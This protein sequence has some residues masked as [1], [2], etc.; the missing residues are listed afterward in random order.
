VV[1]VGRK[2]LFPMTTVT[3][4]RCGPGGGDGRADDAVPRRG[5]D[6]DGGGRQSGRRRLGPRHATEGGRGA[7]RRRPWRR[8][9]GMATV[10]EEWD[11]VA[12]WHGGEGQADGGD[13]VVADG[14]AAASKKRAQE[15]LVV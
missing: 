7:E 2:A 9:S 1:T 14:V 11:S 5:V 4:G 10:E 8:G 3:V 13:S 15:I 6:G 12:P